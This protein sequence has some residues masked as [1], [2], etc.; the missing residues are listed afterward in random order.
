MAKEYRMN[1]VS[2][3]GQG[4]RV[5]TIHLVRLLAGDGDLSSRESA[6]SL[7]YNHLVIPPRRP[8]T[9]LQFDKQSMTECESDYRYISHN[10]LTVCLLC[11][12]P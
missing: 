6:M 1:H 10:Q 9:V 4:L 3:F 11:P 12:R 8:V 5:T 7:N 2:F